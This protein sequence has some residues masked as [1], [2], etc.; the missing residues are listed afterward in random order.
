[1]IGLAPGIDHRLR[2]CLQETIYQ[3]YDIER[4]PGFSELGRSPHVN[5]HADNIML[6]TDVDA[7]SIADKIGTHIGGEY[8]DD[9]D[10]SLWPKLACKADRR[11]GSCAD[12]REHIGFSSG[13]PWQCTAIT[14]DP[15]STG[16]ASGAP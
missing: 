15:N 5:K 8:R 12:T 16:R 1:M 3:E 10:I 7:T 11:I 9:G 13:R 4:Q 2:R 14:Y 6:F